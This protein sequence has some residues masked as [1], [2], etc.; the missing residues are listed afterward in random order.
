MENSGRP[1]TRFDRVNTALRDRAMHGKVVKFAMVGVV[2]ATVDYAVF[3]LAYLYFGLPI[4]GANGLAWLIAVTG[5]Y[6]LNMFFTF[7]AE[8][9]RV[10]RIK[11]YLGFVGSG[12]A[13]F[14]T[15]TLTVLL[16]S[17]LMPVLL[18][19]FIAI[20]VS[21]VVNFSLSHFVVFPARRAQ[22][23]SSQD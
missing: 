7:A 22:A 17:Y 8:S 11:D 4:V 23:P 15:N 16:A 3:A 19:K 10:P 13:G 5:S 1:A 9:G 2:N 18:A 20:G 14:I 12:V 21:F 6:L